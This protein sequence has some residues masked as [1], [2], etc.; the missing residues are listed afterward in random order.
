MPRT[1][2][3]HPDRKPEALNALTRNGFL[4]QG[5]LAGHLGIAT[6]TLSKFFN[7]KP[8][9]VSKF[10]E[11]CDA[12]GLVP[13]ELIRSPHDSDPDNSEPEPDPIEFRA[14]DDCW[15][16]RDALIANLTERMNGSCR[17][18]LLVG[19]TGIGKTALSERLALARQDS[20]DRD[21]QRGFKRADFAH[22]PQTADFASTATRW[23]Q[24]W[25]EPVSPAATQ[26]DLLV[27]RVLDYLQRHRVLV[28]IESLETLLVETE[29]GGE[30]ADGA[31]E[32]FFLD[33]LALESCP[34]RIIVTSQDLP[35]SL[36]Q[37]RYSK[38]WHCHLL[39]G[40]DRAERDA[41]FEATGFDMGADS[42]ERD[43]LWRLGEA[44]RGHPLVLRTI[45][46]DIWESFQGDVLAYWHEVRESVET[47]ERDLAAAEADARETMGAEDRWTLH[48]LTRKVRLEVNRQ[49]LQQTF[50]RLE[51]QSQDAYWLICAASV[52]R[53][54]VQAEG[55]KLQLA[56]WVR[57]VEKR[58][59]A[60][61][62]L[63]RAIDRLHDRFLIEASRNHNRKTVLGQHPLVRGIALERHRQLVRQ[64]QNLAQSA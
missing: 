31:W 26:P 55:W 34:S 61:E 25:G 17:L 50:N 4:T 38:F 6:S 56:N 21:W 51:A 11:I 15:V 3:I 42:S 29:D 1:A 10:E 57:R 54:P 16:G 62:R 2:K 33:F 18:L 24:E 44:Y 58:P 48:K 12:L 53:I 63:E 36:V 27:R 43:P 49:R 45:A 28:A 14:Y 40:L 52:Y 8:I 32:Q 39:L 7:S 35:L 30:F 23:L 59:C 13:Q 60:P 41:L 37:Q 46:G 9:Y 22:A 19:L 5:S 47:I 64:F 20:F